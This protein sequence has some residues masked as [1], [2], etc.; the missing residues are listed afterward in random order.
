MLTPLGA[1]EAAVTQEVK[2]DGRR[3]TVEISGKPDGTPVFLLHGTPG[4]R[5]G[6]RPRGI[7]LYRL[8][9]RLI[10]YDRPGY[11]G[12][13][14]YPGRVI[15]DTAGDVAAIAD[16]LEIDRFCIVGRSGGAPHALA[17]AAVLGDRISS[18]AALGS[19]APF[20]AKGLDWCSGM[21][22]SNIEAYRDAEADEDLAAELARRAGQVRSDPESLLRSLWPELV[23]HDKKIVGDIALRRILADTYA[24]ALQETARGW[25]D[26]VLALRS[27]WGFDFSAITAPVI[28]WHGGD[29]VFSPA[30]HT[31]WLSEQIKNSTLEVQPGAAHFSAVEILPRILAWLTASADAVRLAEPTGVTSGR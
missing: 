31:R 19:L 6:P 9:I 21:A 26:D 2:A 17:C 1:W 13:D 12:S 20:D 29:D 14:P 16:D 28:L 25:I 7:V 22:D 27:A 30:S 3:L 24:E 10:S 4:S 23:S 5:N 15:A 11:G 18:A 8:G